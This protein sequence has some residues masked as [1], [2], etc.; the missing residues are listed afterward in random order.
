MKHDHR[1]GVILG[2]PFD[3]LLNIECPLTPDKPRPPGILLPEQEWPGTGNIII[4]GPPGSGKS[5]LALQFAVACAM[6]E[7]NKSISAYISL[8]N[9][10]LQIR[11]KARSFGWDTYLRDLIC[12]NPTDMSFTPN[13]LSATLSRVFTQSIDFDRSHEYVCSIRAGKVKGSQACLNHRRHYENMNKGLGTIKP[14]VVLSSL[15]PRPIGPNTEQD[16]F[17]IR[18]RQLEGLL[19]AAYQ[20]RTNRTT[21]KILPGIRFIFPVFVIDSLNM[22]TLRSP[23]REELY[24]LFSLFRQ[25]ETAGVFVVESSQETPFDSTLA[26]VVI[27]LGTTREND[28]LVRYI[29]VEKSRFRNQVTG[30]HPFKTKSLQRGDSL[31]LRDDS[32]LRTPRIP[33]KGGHNPK[34][35]DLPRHGVV[36]F[37]SLHYLVRNTEQHTPSIQHKRSI[38]YDAASVWRIPAF[39]LILPS[40]LSRNSVI[41]IEGPRGT[42]K[43]DL[44]VTFLVAGLLADE[45][46]ILVRLHDSPLLVPNQW[47][48][49]S[50]GLYGKSKNEHT[51]F[52]WSM[53]RTIGGRKT[54]VWQR[55]A[56]PEKCLINAWHIKGRMQANLFEID[57]KSGA[58]LPEELVHIVREIIIRRNE[59]GK[60][61]KRIVLDDVGEIGAAYPFLR[62]SSTSGNIFLP[63]FAHVMRNHGVHLII[64]GTTGALPE[65]NEAVNRACAVADTV[66]STRFVDVFG[67]RYVIVRGEGMIAK[68]GAPGGKV[69]M[70]PPVVRLRQMNKDV[71]F[72]IDAKYLEGL[73]GFETG[74]IHRPGLSVHLF[75]DNNGVH[76]EYNHQ[77][78]VMVRSAL[79]REA[80]RHSVRTVNNPAPRVELSAGLL[81]RPHL[82]EGDVSVITFGS[83]E[84][85][86]MH[87]SL[88]V[89]G[90][91]A[92]LDRTV[93][94]TVDEFW[95]TG[96]KSADMFVRLR[97]TD[98]IK[99]TDLKRPFF[100]VPKYENR[101]REEELT[102]KAWPYYLNV[103]LIAYR[104]DV[105]RSLKQHCS[106]WSSLRNLLK[107]VNI[108]RLHRT[109]EV[110]RRFWIDLSASETWSCALMDAMLWGP[111]L[112]QGGDA[113][114]LK[115]RLFPQDRNELKTDQKKEIKALYDLFQY[116]DLEGMQGSER[117]EY[118][119]VLPPD[120]L[121]YVCWYSQL[122]EL[123]ARHPNLAELLCVC[124]LPSKGFTGDWFIGVVNGSVSPELGNRILEKLCSREE[125]Y[126]RFSIGV[127]LPVRRIFYG[128]PEDPA[129]YSWRRGFGNRLRKVFEIHKHAHSRGEIPYYN[130]IRSALSTVAWQL[131]PLAGPSSRTMREKAPEIVGRVIR[132]VRVLST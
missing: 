107:K 32:R 106:Q 81:G 118:S 103:T 34:D 98:I 87:D 102:M 26:D 100:A 27:S 129:F 54:R 11:A 44:A 104:K 122:R 78:D 21:T 124:A 126:R 128:G 55:L 64:A 109:P 57:L 101:L 29:E 37:P 70:V 123:I 13:E 115:D 19:S 39:N 77:V 121:V 33:R 59:P 89:L 30:R 99:D 94:C 41:A 24:R 62:Q 74:N 52:R 113:N 90:V 53:L 60:Q 4:Y 91:G 31:G 25:Y 6:R 1:D 17:W 2:F 15:S 20:L 114:E 9:S 61:V 120:S 76:G 125:E 75:E 105:L 7:E 79:A 36:V 112:A 47:P 3:Q 43:T 16:L 72:E 127:G 42:F 35:G 83:A 22:F 110:R 92:P 119:K 18:Y 95:E 63:A 73:V 5:T 71:T 46:G 38:E 85:E 80:L 88:R 131:M 8:E 132:Q 23:N 56:D 49:L 108:Q 116:M 58:L 50:N 12:L 65:T 96:E 130:K 10:P 93:L 97:A 14:F 68:R 111:T 84:S 86:A 28:Y 82:P 48:V 66:I 45:T 117:D 40:A 51:N 67:E 69:E